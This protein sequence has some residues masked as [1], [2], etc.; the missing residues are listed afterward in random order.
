MNLKER[1]TSHPWIFVGLFFAA[2]ILAAG[3]VNL[4]RAPLWWDEGWTLLVARNWVELGHYGRILNGELDSAGMAGHFPV[5]ASVALSFKL[6]GVG[7]WQG[8]L[9]GLLYTFGAFILMFFLADRLYNRKVARLTIF[10][11][12]F[13]YPLAQ[14]NPIL[15]GRQVLGDMPVVFFL[16]AGYACFLFAWRWPLVAVPLSTCFWGVAIETKAQT[17]PFWLLAMIVP[18][19]VVVVQRRWKSGSF[20]LISLIGSWY[21]SRLIGLFQNYLLS[22]HTVSS[23]PVEGIYETIAFVP[24]LINVRLRALLVVGITGLPLFFGLMYYVWDTY[25]NRRWVSITEGE[26]DVKLS[27]FV[28]A[29]SWFGWFVLL[30]NSGPRYL[31]TPIFIG[32]IFVGAMLYALTDQLDIKS[33]VN[34][35]AQVL[36]LQRFDRKGL[37]AIFGILIAVPMAVVT[38]VFAY[39]NVFHNDQSAIEVADYVNSNS[40]T[41]ALIESYDSE[42]FLFLNRRYHYPPDQVFVPLMQRY[43][44]EQDFEVDY[45]PLQA[46][47]DY[48][49]I[50]PTSAAWRVYD[51]V[52]NLGEF[53]LL[54]NYGR[55]LLYERVRESEY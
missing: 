17:L 49:I 27:M 22:G 48:L 44:F 31:A 36:K 55:Y 37:G 33:T 15:S 6:L 43:M 35:A 2:F 28:F 18:L 1:I 3:L 25:K 42:L 30:S 29:G 12:V 38:L 4:Q 32:S 53:H 46:D 54:Q 16:L 5:V 51:S 23:Q 41:D 52:L 14:T 21:F 34:H 11:L 20:L 39:P 47:P 13:L 45:D 9:P 24:D 10:V 26:E 50:G 7:V 19:V 40:E 8:R